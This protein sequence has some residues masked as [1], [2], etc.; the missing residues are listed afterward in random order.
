VTAVGLND[1]E[2]VRPDGLQF[3]ELDASSPPDAPENW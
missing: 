2:S 1:E 3:P